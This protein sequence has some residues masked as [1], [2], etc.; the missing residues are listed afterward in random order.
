MRIQGLKVPLFAG[1][2]NYHRKLCVSYET[3]EA[4]KKYY[5]MNDVVFILVSFY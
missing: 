3:S 2:E 1:N 4:L 5:D